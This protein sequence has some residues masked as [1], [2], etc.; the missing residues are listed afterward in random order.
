[1]A[2]N[3]RCVLVNHT[4]Q[5]KL[6]KSCSVQ[7]PTSKPKKKRNLYWYNWPNIINNTGQAYGKDVR[8]YQ[9]SE[10]TVQS[11]AEGLVKVW[12]AHAENEDNNTILI[13]KKGNAKTLVLLFSASVI[14]CI[15]ISQL[16]GNF[17]NLGSKYFSH[18]YN[19]LEMHQSHLLL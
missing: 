7:S 16:G 18:L 5:R 12:K 15:Y 10:E 14:F 3:N 13:R 4:F 1:M 17:R 9:A 6:S 11:C 19:S 2:W 8:W